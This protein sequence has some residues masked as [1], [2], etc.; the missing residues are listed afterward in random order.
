MTTPIDVGKQF[1]QGYLQGF[2]T[3][4]IGDDPEGTVE[5]L[6][7]NLGSLLG[8]MGFIPLP[9]IRGHLQGQALARATRFGIHGKSV[10]MWVADK[11]VDAATST[12]RQSKTFQESK[13]LG[14]TSTIRDVVKGG[15]HLGIAS[16]VGS[17]QPWEAAV[18]ERMMGFLGGAE[19]GA[20]SKGAANLFKVG[21]I[22]G[23]SRTAAVAARAISGSLYQGLPTTIHNE[24]LEVQV[25][26]YLLGGY[27]GARDLSL[28]ER[29]VKELMVPYMA[30]P[31]LSWKLM[32]AHSATQKTNGKP[33]EER[34]RDLPE[35]IQKELD[36]QVEQA[37]GRW[38]G[39]AEITGQ[40]IEIKSAVDRAASAS[41]VPIERAMRDQTV[42]SIVD[43]AEAQ[44]RALGHDEATARTMA[45]EE[46]I[47]RMGSMDIFSD[48]PQSSI[49]PGSMERLQELDHF[50]KSVEEGLG[51]RLLRPMRELS[52]AA[53]EVDGQRSP[54]VIGAEIV[55]KM[56]GAPGGWEGLDRLKAIM[57]DEY[58]VELTP[59][60]TTNLTMAWGDAKLG[61]KMEQLVYNQHG[62]I[63]PLG[64]VDFRGRSTVEVKIDS[65]MEEW[66]RE[67]KKG[68]RVAYLRKQHKLDSEGKIVEL[69]ILQEADQ[70]DVIEKMYDAGW[71]YIGGKKANHEMAAMDK[72]HSLVKRVGEDWYF[73]DEKLDTSWYSSDD[74]HA[75]RAEWIS[76]RGRGDTFD[77]LVA[78]LQAIREGINDVK[79]PRQLLG[80][81]DFLKDS[82]AWNKRMQMYLTA[83]MPIDT[84]PVEELVPGGT[85]KGR[86]V[87]WNEQDMADP[88]LV[89]A[90]YGQA[91]KKTGS[92]GALIVRDDIYD[93][94]LRGAGL[95]EEL[96]GTK[97]SI[98]ERGPEGV[99]INKMMLMRP[100]PEMAKAMG[101]DHFRVYTTAAKQR[102]FRGFGKENK[103]LTVEGG[104]T[105]INAKSVRVNHGAS[106]QDMADTTFKRQFA[107][108][109]DAPMAALWE[110]EM[111]R[112][113]LYGNS[114]HNDR[115]ERYVLEKDPMK[116]ETIASTI[117]WDQ[118]GLKHEV[119]FL[120]GDWVQDTPL[121]RKKAKEL[122]EKRDLEETLFTEDGVVDNDSPDMA[123]MF[124]EEIT[125]A[126]RVMMA[127]GPRAYAPLFMQHRSVRP[128]WHTAVHKHV[129][130]SIMRPEAK[131]SWGSKLYLSGLD[132]KAGYYKAANNLAE[133]KIHGSTLGKIWK[134]FQSAGG[135]EAYDA[136]NAR[137]RELGDQLTH[138]VMRVPADSAS[139]VR[140][141]RFNGF[142]GVKG[143]GVHAHPEDMLNLGGADLDGDSVYVYTTTGKKELD[144]KLK[145][146]FLSKKDM[147]M[148][149]SI[150]GRDFKDAENDAFRMYDKR[151]DSV[152]PGGY[153]WR[154]L[155]DQQR[156]AYEAREEIRK[157]PF[158][159]VN[160]L[161]LAEANQWSATG[162][163]MLGRGNNRATR[164]LEMWHTHPSLEGE[165]GP[166]RIVEMY[167]AGDIAIPE[168]R[169]DQ[170]ERIDGLLQQMK[171][172]TG[173]KRLELAKQA[174]EALELG[175]VRFR[176]QRAQTSDGIIKARRDLIQTAADSADGVHL[177]PYDQSKFSLDREAYP[178]QNVIVRGKEYPVRFT[179]VVD[180]HPAYRRLTANHSALYGRNYR[181]NRRMSLEDVYDAL[182][183]ATEYGKEKKKLETALTPA[184]VAVAL[185][186]S[187]LAPEQMGLHGVFQSKIDDLRNAFAQFGKQKG[188][189]QLG[190]ENGVYMTRL[191][192]RYFLDPSKGIGEW[193]AVNKWKKEHTPRRYVADR[194]ELVMQDFWDGVSGLEVGGKGLEVSNVL[195]SRVLTA[196]ERDALA[197]LDP[198]LAT[199]PLDRPLNIDESFDV[200]HA[201]GGAANRVR[202]RILLSRKSPE[203]VRQINEER[204][205]AGKP[206]VEEINSDEAVETYHRT[207]AL[208]PEVARDYFDAYTVS[209][210]YQQ[211][212]T[213]LKMRQK[214]QEM[215]PASWEENQ[216]LQEY[217]KNWMR[218]NWNTMS[219]TNEMVNPA[220]HR[221]FLQTADA[222]ATLSA[223]TENQLV[224]DLTSLAK[225]KYAKFSL[226]TLPEELQGMV[227]P[228]MNDP[229]KTAFGPL[230]HK[231]ELLKTD[232]K[233]YRGDADEIRQAAELER[234][235]RKNPA[236]LTDF[237]RLFAGVIF[238]KTGVG[239]T[240]RL[241][242]K[243]HLRIFLDA[244]KYKGKYF[245]ELDE[246]G[247]KEAWRSRYFMYFPDKLGEKMRAGGF[248]EIT[249]VQGP[250]IDVLGP[251]P[252]EIMRAPSSLM[253]RVVETHHY[254][255][256]YAVSLEEQLTDE[257]ERF[258]LRNTRSIEKWEEI[259]PLVQYMRQGNIRDG[260]GKLREH[261]AMLARKAEAEFNRKFDNGNMLLRAS[262]GG[263]SGSITA[264]E[265]ARIIGQEQTS[266][267]AGR[268]R[269]IINPEG[270]KKLFEYF[271]GHDI[272]DT[273]ATFRKL[274][275]AKQAG[276]HIPQ[277]GIQG[278]MRFGHMIMLDEMSVDY[279]GKKVVIG[280][281]T[282][283]AKAQTLKQLWAKRP[284]L[285]PPDLS[286]KVQ[287]PSTYFPRTGFTA[288]QIEQVIQKEIEDLRKSGV[289]ES[290]RAKKI[291]EMLHSAET[292]TTEDGSIGAWA[293]RMMRS[294]TGLTAMPSFLME[295][296]S[297]PLLGWDTSPKAY[298]TYD[299]KLARAYSNLFAS[300][301][302][303]GR[304]RDFKKSHPEGRE[305]AQ[306][307]EIYNDL[308][309]GGSS[310]FK[311]EL[312]DN[313]KLGLKNSPLYWFSDQKALQMFNKF[314]EKLDVE[315]MRKTLEKGGDREAAATMLSAIHDRDR[316]L[317]KLAALSNGEGKLQMASL[318]FHPKTGLGNLLSAEVN[319]A[320]S[321]GLE[322]WR[323]A[324][325]MRYW[326]DVARLEIPH[327]D[328]NG[329]IT[330]RR[331]ETMQD[332]Y[333]WAQIHGAGESFLND[334][335]AAAN[336]GGQK[337]VAEFL[338]DVKRALRK[339]PTLPDGDIQALAQRH[340][341]TDAV[342]DMSAWV[343]RKTERLARN[344]AFLAHYVKARSIFDANSM[345]YNHA[346]PWLIGFANRGVKATQFLY[347]TADRPMFSATNIGKIFAR[348]QL[349]SWNSIALRQQVYRE[350]RQ[351]GM[352]EGTPEFEK[353]RRMYTADMFVLGIASLFPASVFQSALAP[354]WNI[355]QDAAEFLFGDEKERERAFYGALPY[356]TNLVQPIS[357]PATRFV[358]PVLNSLVSGEWDRFFQRE[359][360]TWFP[361]GRFGRDVYNTME[362]PAQMPERLFG[363]PLHKASAETKKEH[364]RRRVRSTLEKMLG[365]EKPSG[366]QKGGLGPEPSEDTSEKPS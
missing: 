26:E 284:E 196:K 82:Q 154:Q 19:F 281:L 315:N 285:K 219:W 121:F 291:M 224:N 230:V 257:T 99:F 59:R 147:W 31:T 237:E 292:L 91:L 37:V 139:G 252:F 27:F 8:F 174:A 79:M 85:L 239:V 131:G 9:G 235:L 199:L 311:Q 15:L 361:F 301:L 318:L 101:D 342:F 217:D 299:R 267:A 245:Y 184:R 260:D 327:V 74:Y 134:D 11:V 143:Y 253:G 142:S 261:E 48:M 94:I 152:T 209:S 203:E 193:E 337:N 170:R 186:R 46:A 329:N 1:L 289:P 190:P 302:N 16:A 96:G 41:N 55:Q 339:D 328:V 345:S 227:N 60:M 229:M 189:G 149:S 129:T 330:V 155:T 222:V 187:S 6:S 146:F 307:A 119:R 150:T 84:R 241:A 246:A 226:R 324:Q 243:E 225:A 106:E 248:E 176:A 89:T 304:I 266:W 169:P 300:V 56:K 262:Y 109:L 214:L 194:S 51:A 10:P 93:R 38:Y 67:T 274:E 205:A 98:V 192:G 25:Y 204:L 336:R 23:D 276:V 22:T 83:D 356:P 92:D 124:S 17:A 120:V 47:R 355:F 65:P 33:S 5:G 140:I 286:G 201:V 343:M 366:P 297:L 87:Q 287:D 332:V 358:Y 277:A 179:S 36:Y 357:P 115:L 77:H 269:W 24:P 296:S 35:D 319:T 88:S 290:A 162:N 58:K 135:W 316:F 68:V 206:P 325:S 73:G 338:D 347:S 268:L 30:H 354:P 171:D 279:G 363:L 128:L 125:A 234:L 244:F 123:R 40:G 132:A 64:D 320:M 126:E 71:L 365:G 182:D 317:R 54:A 198:N 295:R 164:M 148:T 127:A 61:R 138:F 240:P 351:Y 28:P 168:M 39:D 20:V 181:L 207:R 160:P 306:A 110:Q 133:K 233:G 322:P 80:D 335:M 210:L 2:T 264:R 3:I 280:E 221:S 263:S 216:V 4:S 208:V 273:H 294:G 81:G 249:H 348:F 293:D 105:T 212:E 270:E 86:I 72:A 116:K 272:I 346:D 136:G 180:Q 188:G 141:L 271:P 218:T 167:I 231:E 251:R 259:F 321:V 195:A 352:R 34:L 158:S 21:G 130:D 242:T 200:L 247:L 288:K 117:D 223:K 66:L 238:Q 42:K 323:K 69:P 314:D 173:P 215:H 100:T 97:A 178:V 76:K 350:A 256:R 197:Q 112:P 191:A 185:S 151:R 303:Y 78:N 111:I 166:Q 165:V 102:G 18:D 333:R 57:R 7:R 172:A 49:V 213:D 341:I 90:R 349:Y 331:V 145:E 308:N 360:W 45:L 156:A 326:R 163:D 298:Q 137:A 362:S 122:M 359:V 353:F 14:P 53:A 183:G 75:E 305:W 118:V 50:N 107:F 265:A 32:S 70:V 43:Q 250:M 312:L 232:T 13:I 255:N 62:K 144:A 254:A 161:M 104:E 44:F 114:I 95:P 157:R 283:D 177:A 52:Q 29:R 275:K 175:P 202:D 108:N 159:A 103:D 12:I 344:R 63:Q 211:N 364:D 340:G 220:V 113:A 258:H 313:E 228:V 309:L 282:G 334:M 153:R 236:Y 310:V 278:M